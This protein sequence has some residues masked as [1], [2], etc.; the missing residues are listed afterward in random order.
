MTPERVILI[1]MDSV[2]AGELPDAAVYGDEGSNTLGNI[3]REIPLAIPALRSLGLATVVD[4]GGEAPA[5]RGAAGR[6]A[7][8]S[9][10]KDSVTGHWEMAGL[11]LDKPFPTFPNGFPSGKMREFEARIGR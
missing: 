9:P 5:P 8:S 11:V 1:V 2:G 4:I 7:E 10:G 3:A 6:M